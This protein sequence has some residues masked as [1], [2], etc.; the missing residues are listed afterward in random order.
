MYDKVSLRM[1][2]YSFPITWNFESPDDHLLI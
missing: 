2:V 1:V